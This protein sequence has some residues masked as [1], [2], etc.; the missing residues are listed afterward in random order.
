MART[1]GSGERQTRR[2]LFWFA[3]VIVAVVAIVVVVSVYFGSID[4]GERSEARFPPYWSELEEGELTEAELRERLGPP[5][6][7]EGDCLL[8]DDLVEANRYEFCFD[9][10][11]VLLQKSAI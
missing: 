7:L 9:E 8:Y 6:Q 11:D 1:P 4:D 10:D 3:G 2:G 5:A